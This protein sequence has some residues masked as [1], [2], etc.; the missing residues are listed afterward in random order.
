MRWQSDEVQEEG[1]ELN[2]FFLTLSFLGLFFYE[3]IIYF[4]YEVNLDSC[5]HKSN[6]ER[7]CNCEENKRAQK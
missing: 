4:S 3:K 6:C 2:K 5:D 7:M 1:G